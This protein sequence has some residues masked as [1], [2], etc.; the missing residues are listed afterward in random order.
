[1]DITNYLIN[2][3][4][5][6]GKEFFSKN[7]EDKRKIDVDKQLELIVDTH[8]LLMRQKET[9]IP[10]I[11]S[12][13]GKDIENFKVQIKKNIRWINS[14]KEKKNKG[15]IE[16]F[17]AEEGTKI[18]KRADDT[19]KA[20]DNDL[21]LRLIRRSMKNHEVC[22]GKVDEGSLKVDKYGVIKIR[23]VKY[24]SYNL[25]ECDCYSYIKRLKRREYKDDINDVIKTYVQLS[26]LSEDSEI[27]IR[28]LANYPIEQMRVL[29][30]YRIEADSLSDEEWIKEMNLANKKDGKELL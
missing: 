8:K 30:K 28:I 1:M 4:V 9:I 3:G 14:L 24:I 26:T 12:A 2:N 17:M 21:Y 10:R 19:L 23:T 11:D 16:F 27:Y 15:K 20:L 18:I 22:L 29:S 13:I 6:V 5:I 25:I 7:I